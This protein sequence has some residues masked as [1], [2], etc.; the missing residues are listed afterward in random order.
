MNKWIVFFDD[1]RTPTMHQVTVE[2]FT[3]GD[4]LKAD[5]VPARG[6]WACVLESEAINLSVALFPRHRCR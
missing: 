1:G 5:G 2:G 4:A 3:I 6:V